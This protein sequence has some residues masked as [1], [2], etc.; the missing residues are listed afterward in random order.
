[1]RLGSVLLLPLNWKSTERVLLRIKVK[2]GIWM[3]TEV[4]V[5]QK[6]IFLKCFLI[7]INA[8][9]VHSLLFVIQ[10]KKAQL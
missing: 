9:A 6:I 4:L 1:M 2:E 3:Q 8:C 10:P 5:I 7:H